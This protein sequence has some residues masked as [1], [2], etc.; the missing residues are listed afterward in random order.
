MLTSLSLMKLL[1]HHLH[2]NQH[3][4]LRPLIVIGLLLISTAL[5]FVASQHE[6]MLIFFLPM[7]VGLVLTFLRWSSL[8]LSI[9]DTKQNGRTQIL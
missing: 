3:L 1:S 2:Q 9:V 4:W 7:G 8:G 5:P 6:L